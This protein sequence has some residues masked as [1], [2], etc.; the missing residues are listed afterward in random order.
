MITLL[1]DQNNDKY[2]SVHGMQKPKDGLDYLLKVRRRFGFYN[3]EA[4]WD[5]ILD[6][7]RTGKF[8]NITLDSP[9]EVPE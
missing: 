9:E 6:C 5:H 3:Y 7:L 4:A 1:E 8:G 2:Y